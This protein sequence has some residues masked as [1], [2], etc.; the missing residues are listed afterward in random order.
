MVSN[1]SVANS[2]AT[3]V[4]Y[5]RG[6]K[7][8]V[9][10]YD[11]LLLLG[12]PGKKTPTVKNDGFTHVDYPS[13]LISSDKNTVLM[14]QASDA[15]VRNVPNPAPFHATYFYRH[16]KAHLNE[17]HVRCLEHERVKFP[18]FVLFLDTRF[19]NSRTPPP[20]LCCY[21]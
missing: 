3:Y 21:S 2:R 12:K 1:V 15:F 5:I 10:N 9:G 13:L 7:M 16:A 4:R 20:P 11:V 8:T 17:L 18:T 14:I 6:R 19:S